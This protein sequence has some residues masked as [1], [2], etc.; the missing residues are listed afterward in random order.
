MLSGQK[1]QLEQYLKLCQPMQEECI[2]HTGMV[3]HRFVS[4]ADAVA[5]SNWLRQ[6]ANLQVLGIQKVSAAKE[7]DSAGKVVY[8]VRLTKEQQ[9]TIISV[10]NKAFLQVN[11][12]GASAFCIAAMMSESAFISLLEKASSVAI[13]AGLVMQTKNGGIPLHTAAHYQGERG[14]IALLEKASSAAIDAAVIMQTKDDGWIPLHAA[15]FYQR[16]GGFIALL[17][18]ASSEAIDAALVMQ[19]KSGWTPLNTA[20][21]SQG[22]GGFI[23]LLEKASSEVIDAALVMQQEAGWTPLHTAARYQGERGFIALLEKTSSEAIDAALVMQL[24]DGWTSLHTAARYQGES[25]F[26]ALLEKASSAVIDAA[27]VMQLEDGGTPLHLIGRYQGERGFLA[28][29]EKVSPVA[30]D[31]A[32]V[33]QQEDGGTPLHIIMRYQSERASLALLKKVSPS[34]FTKCFELEKED[35]WSEVFASQ[36]PAICAMLLKMTRA[37]G[38]D[39]TSS[40]F[41]FNK[42]VSYLLHEASWQ[43]P[44]IIK[45]CL[46]IM[47]RQ[48]LT[49]LLERGRE[50]RALSSELKKYLMSTGSELP[51]TLSQLSKQDLV[52]DQL[53]RDIAQDKVLFKMIDPKDW[54]EF[55]SQMIDYRSRP[56]TLRKFEDKKEATHK[57]RHMTG[58]IESFIPNKAP[59]SVYHQYTRTKKLATTLMARNMSTMVFGERQADKPLVGLMF[60]RDHC[61]LKAL[62]AKDSATYYRAWVGKQNEVEQYAAQMRIFNYTKIDEFA[63]CVNQQP[64]RTSEVLAELSV[65]SMLSIVIARDIPAARKIARDRQ[66]EMQK[67]LNVTLPI[68]FYDNVVRDITPYTTKQAQHD[69]MEFSEEMA[70]KKLLELQLKISSKNNWQ[71]ISL[72]SCFGIGQ[73]L[74]MPKTAR[75]VLRLIGNA[76]RD[77]VGQYPWQSTLQAVE[78]LLATVNADRSIFRYQDTAHFYQTAYG[79]ITKKM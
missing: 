47:P 46:D 7:A 13:D 25:G 36:S 18:K 60:N 28:L 67:K 53:K 77:V 58:Q 79:E 12:A 14:F 11:A 72:F 32:L 38:L 66:K 5:L 65:A 15:A 51:F 56:P 9:A 74:L 63:A 61:K 10:E 41:I 26:I 4:E 24:K 52:C 39:K 33:M 49:S 69:E 16:E 21:F 1:N 50:G 34:A 44:S 30:I 73:S 54:Q 64:H 59:R 6:Q 45:L 68:V 17:K 62:L 31:A 8:V 37:A 35:L 48:F 22:E 55:L 19:T 20:A 23:A 27:L 29:L 70:K 75:T 43:D 40:L 71:T 42:C 3:Q 57:F 2:G 78:K 76:Q